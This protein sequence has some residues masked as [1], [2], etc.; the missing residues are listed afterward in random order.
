MEQKKKRFFC[1]TNRNTGAYSST[2]HQH[3]V[4]TEAPDRNTG[5][6]QQHRTATLGA[7]SSTGQQ[8]WVHTAVPD[9]NTGCTQQHRTA[10]LGAH[11]NTGQQHWISVATANTRGQQLDMLPSTL[12][13]YIVSLTDVI[14]D[15]INT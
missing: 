8:H 7:H 3:W 2:G 15:K 12:A 5:C 6:T 13:P 11:S 14:I 1:I 4:H 9:S 10:T